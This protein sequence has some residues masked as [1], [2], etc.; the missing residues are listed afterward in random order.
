M[1][2][3]MQYGEGNMVR[4]LTDYIISGLLVF[5]IENYTQLHI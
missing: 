1:A 2:C 3:V 5:L 4:S